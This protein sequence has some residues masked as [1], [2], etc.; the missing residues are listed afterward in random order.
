MLTDSTVSLTDS[1]V[2]DPHVGQVANRRKVADYN[3]C[4]RNH[5]DHNKTPPPH[6]PGVYRPPTPMQTV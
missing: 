2:T 1:T 4:D 3:H 6:H 5:C